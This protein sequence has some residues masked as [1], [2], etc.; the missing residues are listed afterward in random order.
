M[1]GL[2]DDCTTTIVETY[3]FIAKA[4]QRSVAPHWLQLEVSMAQVKVLF[5]LYHKGASTISAIAENL[6]IGLPTASHLVERLVRANLVQR[7]E[8][9]TDR[10]QILASLTPQGEL[11]IGQLQYERQEQLRQWVAQLTGEERQALAT[12]LQALSHV[13]N[14]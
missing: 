10:R 11:L 1:S 4:L 5:V 14:W 3:T 6:E 7:S 8:G 2:T 12:G 9:P 13:V